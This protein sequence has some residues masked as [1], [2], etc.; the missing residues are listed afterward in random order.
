MVNLGVEVLREIAESKTKKP[1]KLLLRSQLYVK[2]IQRSVEKIVATAKNFKKDLH[3]GSFAQKRVVKT[4]DQLVDELTKLEMSL[5]ILWQTL[6][7]EYAV[8]HAD[9]PQ[10]YVQNLQQADKKINWMLK[11]T[12]PFARGKLINIEALYPPDRK[13]SPD[14]QYPFPEQIRHRSEVIFRDSS[15][16]IHSL[17]D[18]FGAYLSEISELLAIEETLFAAEINLLMSEEVGKHFKEYGKVYLAE[19]LKML[20]KRFAKHEINMEGSHRLDTKTEDVGHSPVIKAVLHLEMWDSH[21]EQNGHKLGYK[22]ASAQIEYVLNSQKFHVKVFKLF[23][24]EEGSVL[25]GEKDSNSMAEILMYFL[26][27]C[28]YHWEKKSKYTS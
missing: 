18:V 24:I 15:N 22:K 9:W 14:G 17:E 16:L 3:A 21:Y 27:K 28:G 20:N 25:W 12:L 26:E 4:H 11:E 23:S 6:G 13:D 10:E 1:K 8:V 2:N 19:I 7:E 5:E